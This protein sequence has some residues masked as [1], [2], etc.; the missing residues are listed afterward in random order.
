VP[1]LILKVGERVMPTLDALLQLGG[2]P[3]LI[4]MS[5][6]SLKMD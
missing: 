1:A 6:S 2:E 3:P 4:P 5:I